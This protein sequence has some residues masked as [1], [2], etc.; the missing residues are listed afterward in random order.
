MVQLRDRSLPYD[1]LVEEAHLL[2]S[3]CARA[4]V[5]FIVND[6][7]ELARRCEADGVH[8]GQTDGTIAHARDVLGSDRIVGRTSRGGDELG[9]AESEGADY[10]SVSPDLGDADEA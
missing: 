9:R 2:S 8:L 3:A 1:D 7:V 6:D 10:A 5:L 4:G